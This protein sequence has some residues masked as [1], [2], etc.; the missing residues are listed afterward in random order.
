MR[1][2]KVTEWRSD[3]VVMRRKTPN[4]AQKMSLCDVKRQKWKKWRMINKNFNAIVN[5]NN[6]TFVSD[7]DPEIPT[8]G[9]TDN[10]GN[11]VNLVSGII[12]LPSSWDF[13]VCIR[14]RC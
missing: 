7:A 3:N 2:H 10:A 4:D 1:Y 5:E 8:L 11:S 9:S 6:Q 12:R 14:D 13:S